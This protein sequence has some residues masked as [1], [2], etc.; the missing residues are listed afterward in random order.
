LLEGVGL[1]FMVKEE[2]LLDVVTGISGSGPAY[3]FLVMKLMESIA[4][5]YGLSSELSRQLV[6]QT[7][8]GAGELALHSKSPLDQL[9]MSVA[10]P[11]GT[12]EEALRVL[13]SKGFEDILLEAISAA[14][15][16]SKKWAIHELRI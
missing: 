7:C 12:T 15:E 10:S 9:I 16:K 3:F 6:A 5:K 8:K 13:N 1:A 2:P 14:I 4:Q 11:G